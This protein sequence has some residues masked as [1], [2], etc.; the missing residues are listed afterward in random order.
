MADYIKNII[1]EEAKK[2]ITIG[3]I[4][5]VEKGLNI[6]L[7]EDY[8]KHLLKYNG[9]HPI[10]DGAPMIN[11][12]DESETDIG[13]DWFLAIYEGESSNFLKAY[14]TFKI[15]QKRMPDELIPIANASCGDKI[16]MSVKGDNYEKIY[17]WEHEI[18]ASEGEEPDYSNVHLIANSFA[19]FINSL[20]GSY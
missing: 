16:C 2:Q 12:I 1:I 6:N 4:T 20:L 8:K 17:Y 3:D 13:I 18:E 9:G 15:W 11:P 19:D 10:K 7:P 14:H 5:K